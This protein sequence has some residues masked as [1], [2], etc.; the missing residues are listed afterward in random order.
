MKRYITCTTAV[1]LST[2]GSVPTQ[3]E[4][5]FPDTES[6]DKQEILVL[7]DPVVLNLDEDGFAPGRGLGEVK[8]AG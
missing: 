3:A 7:I 4:D 1:V 5:R 6:L 2:G 8:C